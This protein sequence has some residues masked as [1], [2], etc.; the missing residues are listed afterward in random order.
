MSET[1]VRLVHSHEITHVY[2]ADFA[3]D[4]CMQNISYK[5]SKYLFLTYYPDTLCHQSK[6]EGERHN[7]TN[8][9][10]YPNALVS[11]A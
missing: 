1:M 3:V 4:I 9:R 5:R 7:Q 2:I 10:T 8:T 11:N 6:S